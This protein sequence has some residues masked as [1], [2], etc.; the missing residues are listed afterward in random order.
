MVCFS[1]YVHSEGH[2]GLERKVTKLEAM[3]KMLQE[4]LK[5]VGEKIQYMHIYMH[6]AHTLY[7]APVPVDF[8]GLQT[9]LCVVLR[10]NFLVPRLYS[11][12]SMKNEGGWLICIQWSREQMKI[13]I[14][15]SESTQSAVDVPPLLFRF[16]SA[17]HR[18]SLLTQVSLQSLKLLFLTSRHL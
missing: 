1:L 18:C 13:N 3:V 10:D 11:S 9:L 8:C 2:I 15:P 12:T 14:L 5:K 6:T 7:D 4:D 17:A 16:H